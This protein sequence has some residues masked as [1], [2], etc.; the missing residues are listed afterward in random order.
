MQPMAQ[1]F[2]PAEV[3]CMHIVSFSHESVKTGQLM[4]DQ[5]N[6]NGMQRPTGETAATIPSLSAATAVRVDRFLA[7]LQQQISIWVIGE[8]EPLSG[9][10]YGGHVR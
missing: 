3:V 9:S 10:K 1:G 7:Q 4:L 5:P 2:A 8:A 6:S